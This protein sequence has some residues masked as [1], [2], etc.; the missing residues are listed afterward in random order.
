MKILCI[1]LFGSIF[2][3]GCQNNQNIDSTVKKIN[4]N[5]YYSSKKF[6]IGSSLKMNGIEKVCSENGWKQ[7][8]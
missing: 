5:C 6:S 8:F 7:T 4:Q 1:L 2:F 3:T